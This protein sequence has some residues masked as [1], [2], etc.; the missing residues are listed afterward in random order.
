MFATLLL[1]LCAVALLAPV[2]ATVVVR[3]RERD[4]VSDAQK[5][6]RTL[7]IIRSSTPTDRKVLKVL[8][9]GQSITKSGWDKTVI[10]HWHQQYPNTVFVVQNRALGGFPSQ[11]LVRATEQDIAAF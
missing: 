5:I 3:Y 1:A 10:E 6:A 11:A 8:F 2:V 9:Y 4:N 7:G